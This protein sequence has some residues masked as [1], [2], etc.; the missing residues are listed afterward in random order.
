LSEAQGLVDHLTRVY[1]KL[2]INSRELLADALAAG[3]WA[4]LYS[5]VS[6][7]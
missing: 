4:D 5:A 6:A 2:D 3:E 7:C 1:S